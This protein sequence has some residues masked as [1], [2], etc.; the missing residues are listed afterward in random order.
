MRVIINESVVYETNRNK[1]SLSSVP[2]NTHTD[3]G[4]GKRHREIEEER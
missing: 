1:I 3:G 4:E 2:L